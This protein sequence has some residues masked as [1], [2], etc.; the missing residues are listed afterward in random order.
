MAIV[1]LTV[2]DVDQDPTSKARSYRLIVGGETYRADLC[3]EHAAPL[4]DVMAIATTDGKAAALPRKRRG[5]AARVKTI[6]EIEAEKVG[7]ERLR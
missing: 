4:L 5:F 1:N 2:C 3:D 7:R 6:E